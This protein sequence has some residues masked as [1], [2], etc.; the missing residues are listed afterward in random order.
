MTRLL[1]I[2]FAVF[3]SIPASS[4]ANE[5]AGLLRSD[6]NGALPKGLW[7][8]QNRSEITYLLQNLPAHSDSRAMQEIKRNM[9]LSYYKT[10]E[11]TNDVT[12]EDA[13]TCSPYVYKN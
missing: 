3:I 5:G 7:R 9:L 10:R 1:L 6:L 12:L 8:K 13:K 11:I 4:Q 2:L